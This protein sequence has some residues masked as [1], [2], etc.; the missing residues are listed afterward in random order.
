[1][2]LFAFFAHRS[3]DT[4]SLLKFVGIQ[5]DFSGVDFIAE[6]KYSVE[7]GFPNIYFIY[8]IG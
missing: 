2:S 8:Y 3:G 4:V 7:T 6:S 1:M 5:I